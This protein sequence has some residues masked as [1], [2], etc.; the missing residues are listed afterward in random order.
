MGYWYFT[1]IAFGEVYWV[2]SGST[3]SPLLADLYGKLWG[4]LYK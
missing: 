4:Q 2:T 3:G 1:Y